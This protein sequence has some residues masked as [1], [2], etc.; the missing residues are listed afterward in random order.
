MNTIRKQ[1]GIKLLPINIILILCVVI[2]LVACNKP[3]A[4][5]YSVIIQNDY[6]ETL[7]HV[8]IAHVYLDSI[9]TQHASPWSVI[10]GGRCIFT[11]R[12]H[13]GIEWKTVLY[14]R[15]NQS[16]QRI[17]IDKYAQVHIE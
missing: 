8:K 11:A 7:H 4:S 16:Q 2:I 1:P 12:S 6:F 14:I 9:A 17:R 5:K 13:T 15:G 10:D 3:L